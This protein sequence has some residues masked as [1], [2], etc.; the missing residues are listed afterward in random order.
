M[1]IYRFTIK[2]AAGIFLFELLEF[3]LVDL[4][5]ALDFLV[6]LLGFNVQVCNSLAGNLQL[7]GQS[8][9]LDLPLFE[10]V[11]YYLTLFNQSL[12]F[13]VFLGE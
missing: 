2:L 8:S 11:I 13:A 7:V 4:V 1:S 5:D 3:S 12:N 9:Q 6:V 10:A